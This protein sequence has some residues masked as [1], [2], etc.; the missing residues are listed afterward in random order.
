MKCKLYVAQ[1]LLA[2]TCSSDSAVDVLRSNSELRDILLRISSYN[3]QQQR[4]R[5]L[6]YPGE[7]FKSA[8]RSKRKEQQRRRPFIEA[9]A[10]KD[11]LTGKVQGTA[12]QVLAAIGYNQ[13]VPKIPG[14][15]GLRILCMDG[16]G[17][18]GMTAVKVLD[19]LV[20]SLDGVEAADCF[21]LV[22]G[23]ST[24]AIIA[25][26]VGLKRDTS[27]R[28]VDRYDDLIGKIL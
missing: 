26:L 27:T 28:A 6:R 17:S 24:G 10:L 14:Q 22:V 8:V 13:W 12:N 19:C 7:V 15:K 9:T 18:R 2:M 25:F 5:W 20:K 16:G 11:D 4:R 3:R 1:L 23:T 21:D